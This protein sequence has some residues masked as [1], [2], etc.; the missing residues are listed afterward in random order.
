MA[1]QF[2]LGRLQH[3]FNLLAILQNPAIL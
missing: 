2:L 1:V 3:W